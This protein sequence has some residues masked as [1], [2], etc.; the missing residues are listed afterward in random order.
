MSKGDKRKSGIK[1]IKGNRMEMRERRRANEGTSEEQ[2]RHK[3]HQGED[4]N[5]V[6]EVKSQ[7]EMK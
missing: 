4:W 2:R 7:R 6:G 5:Q 1:R 3:E